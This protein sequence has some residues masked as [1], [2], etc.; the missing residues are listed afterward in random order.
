MENGI[1][2]KTV[3]YSL[4]VSAYY[5]NPQAKLYHAQNAGGKHLGVEKS[6]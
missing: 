4:S 5:N 3:M 1:V 2:T 6:K